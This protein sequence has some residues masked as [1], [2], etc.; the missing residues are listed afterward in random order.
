MIS[1]AELRD[2]A[3]VR[4]AEVVED[5][6]RATPDMD[7]MERAGVVS[8]MLIA[9]GIALACHHGA[10]RDVVEEALL[11]KVAEIYGDKS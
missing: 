7:A 6:K 5:L 2:L 9:T 3:D 10:P 1:R 8:A 4:F 11:A